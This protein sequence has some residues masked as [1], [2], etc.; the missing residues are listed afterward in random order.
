MTRFS[1]SKAWTLLVLL[2]IKNSRAIKTSGPLS[3]HAQDKTLQLRGGDLGPLDGKTIAT[4]FSALAGSD[5]ICGAIIPRTSMSWFGMQIPKGS[6]SEK[7]L[8]GIGASAATVAVSIY[9]AVNGSPVNEAIAYGLVARLVSMTLMILTDDVLK[10]GMGFP[11][12]GGLW[13]TFAATAYSLLQGLGD[14]LAL[15][16]VVSVFLAVHGLFLHLY[17]GVIIRTTRKAAGPD[18]MAKDILSIN[19]GYMIASA[20]TTFLLA[21]GHDPVKVAGYTAISFIPIMLKLFETIE[22]GQVFGVNAGFLS[23][24]LTAL[25]S[26]VIVGTLH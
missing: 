21:R 22:G 2:Q 13:L 12:F 9:F 1:W 8:H 14:A 10:V 25:M 15:T 4:T 18:P 16:K 17:P 26:C 23:M 19:G 7:Y 20:V 3:H 24:S 6:L 11:L 5:A